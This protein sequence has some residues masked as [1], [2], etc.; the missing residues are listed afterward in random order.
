MAAIIYPIVLRFRT[1][2]LRFRIDAYSRQLQHIWAQREN[3]YE[4]ER[5]LH[6]ELCAARTKLRALNTNRVTSEPN[7]TP[8]TT[9]FCP[10]LV[11]GKNR[12]D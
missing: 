8:L 4:A 12:R 3:D 5:L 11:K 6:R 2:W 7:E 1:V 9:K 10:S